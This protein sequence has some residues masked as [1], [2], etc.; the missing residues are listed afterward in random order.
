[1]AGAELVILPSQ[2]S[3]CLMVLVLAG[4]Q[5]AET[6]VP[7]V[8]VA[9]TVGAGTQNLSGV[10]GEPRSGNLTPGQR[11]GREI[12][13]HGSIPGGRPIRAVLGQSREPVDAAL[14]ACGNCHGHDGR[15]RPEGGVEPPDVT[16]QALCK[17]Y[18]ATD[19]F[20]RRR[21]AYTESLLGRV[22]TMGLD[23]SGRQLEAVMPRYLLSPEDLAD[24][25]A[26]LTVLG[27]DL[28]PG[29]SSS[30]ITI[31]ALLPPERLDPEWRQAPLSQP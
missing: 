5:P 11:R 21:P 14:L 23:S 30:T 9:T 10:A 13:L 19:R 17:P 29:L 7:R 25:V 3:A 26:Y 20:G 12:Y 22:V 2:A 15:G 4:C 27:G 16:W 8:P 28:D 6:A 31:G 18:G 24:L 1:L